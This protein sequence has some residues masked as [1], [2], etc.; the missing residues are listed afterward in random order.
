WT[1]SKLGMAYDLKRVNPATIWNRRVEALLAYQGGAQTRD[2]LLAST[3][4]KLERLASRSEV[5]L[6]SL[7]ARLHEQVTSSHNDLGELR[8]RISLRMDEW[9]R[10]RD[11]RS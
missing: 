6:H 5:R 2:K 4:L 3:R 1:M 7:S 10:A 8:R 9:K 11:R